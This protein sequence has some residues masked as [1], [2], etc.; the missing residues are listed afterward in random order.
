MEIVIL[1]TYCD[2]K[3]DSKKKK[4]QHPICSE[5]R[6]ILGGNSF[7]IGYQ[8]SI[9]L[10]EGYVEKLKYYET[11]YEPAVIEKLKNCINTYVELLSIGSDETTSDVKDIQEIET[12][13]FYEFF[14][15]MQTDPISLYDLTKITTFDLECN[16]DEVKIFP[17][18]KEKYCNKKSY[19]VSKIKNLLSKRLI[20][21]EHVQN[22]I[23]KNC[24]SLVLK[25]E[26]EHQFLLLSV[27][28]EIPLND[29]RL[30]L[31]Y[32]IKFSRKQ[33]VYRP[34]KITDPVSSLGEPSPTR[35]SSTLKPDEEVFKS[36][37]QNKVNHY[38]RR[39]LST[40]GKSELNVSV[41]KEVDT[42]L[43]LENDKTIIRHRHRNTYDTNPRQLK[44]ELHN[45]RKQIMKDGF[46]LDENY[47]LNLISK[48]SLGEV[49][50]R[51]ERSDLWAFCESRKHSRLQFSQIYKFLLPIFKN[52]PSENSLEISPASFCNWVYV[53][54]TAK[55]LAQRHWL[56]TPESNATL[57]KLK[58]E[59]FDTLSSEEMIEIEN[60]FHSIR[61]LG[62][63]LDMLFEPKI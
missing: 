17:N 8:A 25:L 12:D 28:R 27:D 58:N 13:E 42:R 53:A 43:F 36:G 14:Q 41:S 48:A 21:F 55:A 63:S 7:E 56:L 45:L 24:D 22:L 4:T 40:S 60:L 39:R 57:I 15:L 34:N 20:N 51:T 47:V 62:E 32:W 18:I 11:Q 35:P 37:F 19:L 5:C 16:F 29:R 6:D 10:M 31:D 49:F 9:Q 61:S 23:I 54:E 2:D 52:N 59:C 26:D 33:D 46:Q 1:C 3:V 38:D 50:S 44:R 30:I